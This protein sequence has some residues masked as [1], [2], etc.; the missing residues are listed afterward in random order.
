MLLMFATF[1]SVDFYATSRGGRA[2]ADRDD[3]FDA[4]G[5]VLLLLG[6]CGKSAQ[7]PL[8]CG[9]PTRWRARRRCRP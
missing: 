4:V 2:H 7:L 3:R 9:C 5:G 1:G 6:A 8:Q